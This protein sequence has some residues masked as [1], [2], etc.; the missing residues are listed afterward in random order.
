MS[1]EDFFDKSKKS[2]DG[3]TY[4]NL[5]VSAQLNQ[6]GTDALKNIIDGKQNVKVK[7]VLTWFDS[8]SFRVLLNNQ[9]VNL[10]LLS[11]TEFQI[12]GQGLSTLFDLDRNS[13][14]VVSLDTFNKNLFDENFWIKQNGLIE[15]DLEKIITQLEGE[16]IVLSMP[17]NFGGSSSDSDY[18]KLSLEVKNLFTITVPKIKEQLEDGNSS[19]SS[20]EVTYQIQYAN[21]DETKQFTLT[22]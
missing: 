17:G 21:T 9:E 13:A 10:E 14:Y 22:F 5:T 6:T 4:S 7:D 8:F 2:D 12:Q 18:S 19:P 1:F 11:N 16:S 3:V 20:T 15:S